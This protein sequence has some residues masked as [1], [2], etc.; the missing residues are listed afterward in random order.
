MDFSRLNEILNK[1]PDRKIGV[2]GDCCLDVYWEVDMKRSVLSLET[3]EFPLP[4]VKERF[5]LG[6]AGNVVNNLSVLNLK[7]IDFLT[8]LGE[9][10][11]KGI[12]LDILRKL[13][14]VSV[15]NTII[16]NKRVTPAYCKPRKH[17]ISNVVYEGSRLDFWNLEEPDK[18]LEEEILKNLEIMS[19][20]VDVIIVEDQLKNGIL[21][22]RI[23]G[24]INR[25]GKQGKKIIVDSRN[26]AY[27][28]ENILLKPNDKELTYMADMLGIKK[29]HQD[30]LSLAKAVSKNTNNE[31]VVTLGEKGSAWVWTDDIK[32]KDAFLVEGEIDIVGAGDG[33]ISGLASMIDL[34]SQEDVLYLCNLISSIIIR[35]IGETGSASPD[36]IRKEFIKISEDPYFEKLE[37]VKDRNIRCVLMDFDGTISTLRCGW[38]EVMLQFIFK[39]L[40]PFYVG[41]EDELR[42]K[43]IRFIDD[44]TGVQTIYQMQWIVQ[45][46]ELAGGQALDQWE[47]KEGFNTAL[48]E[49][50]YKRIKLL[51]EGKALPDD[52]LVPGSKELVEKM[53]EQGMKCF[54]AS[55]TDDVDLKKEM[56]ILGVGHFFEEVKGAPYKKVACAKEEIYERLVTEFKYQPDEI[57][58]VGDGKVEIKL[59]SEN[60]ALT[61][62]IASNERDFRE[63]DLK[64]RERLL[65]AKASAIVKDFTNSDDIIGWMKG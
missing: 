45:Q 43:I 41:K 20:N 24:E 21:T 4:I 29:D 7:E 1:I 56:N 54:I 44:S 37:E 27:Q 39:E 52:F 15:K 22:D 35:K 60:G 55:G 8:V 53:V 58:I 19:E 50:V 31:L 33:F 10:W 18:E 14:N 36:E 38:E 65:E 30:I 17:G 26:M 48:I 32:I 5:S 25:L 49:M 12:V 62:G 28:Y 63:V 46:V 11:R 51:E 61:L 57:L 42:E 6:A 2:I 16:T 9:D 40:S 64:K 47:Y 59:G 23:R 13:K 3:P 34:T